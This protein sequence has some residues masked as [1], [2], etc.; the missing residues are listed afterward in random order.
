MA[1]LW[2]FAIAVLFAADPKKFRLDAIPETRDF[3]LAVVISL[4]PFI[5]CFLFG[6]CLFAIGRGLF[7]LRPWT[8]RVC[9][10]VPILGA[11]GIAIRIFVLQAMDKQ[12]MIDLGIL[13]I[14][15]L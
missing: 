5:G 9:G 1:T 6:P 3:R 11:A 10:L 13:S 15:S 8:R 14:I 7:R 2:S 4:T 12:V